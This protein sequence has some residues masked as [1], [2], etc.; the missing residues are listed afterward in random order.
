MNPTKYTWSEMQKSVFEGN[1]DKD[2]YMFVPN[3]L[4]SL[5]KRAVGKNSNV[6]VVRLK[7]VDVR[8]NYKLVVKKGSLPLNE[9]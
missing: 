5:I 1:N 9:S 3:R 8:G 4:Y 6:K 2:L 7:K